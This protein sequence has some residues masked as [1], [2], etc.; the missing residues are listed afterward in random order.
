MDCTPQGSSVH[1]ILWAK[2]LE[3]VVI[4]FTRESSWPR[5]QTQVSHIEGRFFTVLAT[6]EAKKKKKAQIYVIYQKTDLKYKDKRGW[7]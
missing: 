7:I 2:L 5:D 1:G 4:P 6:R 3:W